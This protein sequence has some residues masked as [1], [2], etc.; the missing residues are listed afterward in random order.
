MTKN[1]TAFHVKLQISDSK[2][3]IVQGTR[4][5]KVGETRV[6]SSW[7]LIVL[8][9]HS[10]TYADKVPLNNTLLRDLS[11]LSPPKKGRENNGYCYLEHFL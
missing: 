9:S 1:L 5:T 3:N 8:S 10:H 7:H 2:L 6:S 11:C 4:T